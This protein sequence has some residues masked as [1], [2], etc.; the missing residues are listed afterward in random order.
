MV[1]KTIVDVLDTYSDKREAQNK[2]QQRATVVAT[3][4]T[5]ALVRIGGSLQNQ[6][7]IIPSGSQVEVGDFVAVERNRSETR[8]RWIIV[9][10]ISRRKSAGIPAVER[11]YRELYP[12]ANL[13]ELPSAIPGTIT[14]QWDVP[15]TTPVA[16]QVQ[17]STDL[18]VTNS[19][20]IAQVRG[21]F[22]IIETSEVTLDIRVRSVHFDGQ[23]SGWTDWIT[24]TTPAEA[25]TQDFA[26]LVTEYGELVWDSSGYFLTE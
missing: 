3:T 12:P 26:K 9:S 7:A 17:T 1:R 8:V 20:M 10:V 6:H 16:F 21:G 13:V 19:T 2:L 15:I 25:A 11:D 5:T 14:V 24:A 18:G 23:L 22:A 4:P